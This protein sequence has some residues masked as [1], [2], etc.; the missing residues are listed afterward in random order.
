MSETPLL[1][2]L[3]QLSQ[4]AQGVLESAAGE[5]G[6]ESWRVAYLGRRGRLTLLLRQLGSLAVE[7]RRSVGAEANR[8][9]AALEERFQERNQ[10]LK[11]SRN[12]P[13]TWR[14]AE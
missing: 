9:K 10:A 6:L 11:A 4:E 3:A 1:D 13:G 8:V 2:E 7:E 5:D 14:R 12:A